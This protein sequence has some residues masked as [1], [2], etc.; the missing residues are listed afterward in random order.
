MHAEEAYVQYPGMRCRHRR[1]HHLQ[2]FHSG[3]NENVPEGSGTLLKI[4]ERVGDF[5]NRLHKNF[6][7]EGKKL[8]DFRSTQKI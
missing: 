1:C 6:L 3:L 8:S 7:T 2:S 4:G 5:Q